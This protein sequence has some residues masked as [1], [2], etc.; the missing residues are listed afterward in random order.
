MLS[1]INGVLIQYYVTCITELWYF[2]HGINMD[3]F[4]P[5][6]QIG[7]LIHSASYK[8][9]SKN[10][11][12]NDEIAID[13]AKYSKKVIYEV[14]KSSKYMIGAKY[15]LLYYLYYLK[16]KG[17]QMKGVLSVPK[18]KLNIEVELGEKEEKEIKDIINEI[19]SVVSMAIPPAPVKKPYCKGCSYYELCWS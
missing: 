17:I 2:S 13:I 11:N 15:Q 12:I 4:S 19:P 1:K 9:A 7:K 10:I 8:Q 5:D 16:N 14:K 3:K 18:E 6:M